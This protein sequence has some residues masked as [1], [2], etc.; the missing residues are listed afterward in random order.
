M[1][2]PFNTS[3]AYGY[4]TPVQGTV[5]IESTAT[6]SPTGTDTLGPLVITL[7]TIG[8]SEDL[9]LIFSA[10]GSQAVYQPLSSTLCVIKG[11]GSNAVGLGLAPA[12]SG[13][14]IPISPFEPNLL[15]FPTTNPPPANTGQLPAFWV[16]AAGAIAGAVEITFR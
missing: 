7:T 2:A 14:F 10:A 6:S 3:G 1:S 15:T 5:T 9:S 4:V 11:P 12:A 8:T 16:V 13:L